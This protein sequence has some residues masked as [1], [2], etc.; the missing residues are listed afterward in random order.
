MSGLPL[1]SQFLRLFVNSLEYTRLLA[2]KLLVP[3]QIL[4]AKVD[5]QLQ[6]L[7]VDAA[8]CADF[9]RAEAQHTFQTG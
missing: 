4:L 8:I 9:T 5:S 6:V 2:F 1:T 7:A 3:L